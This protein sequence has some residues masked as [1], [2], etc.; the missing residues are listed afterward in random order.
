M[1]L[2][3]PIQSHIAEWKKNPFRCSHLNKQLPEEQPHGEVFQAHFRES[4][5]CLEASLKLLC[6]NAHSIGNEQDWE[7]SVQLQD[8]DLSG[9]TET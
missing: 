2:E 3:E 9:I 8:F 1:G 5:A 4:A 7:I 6:T